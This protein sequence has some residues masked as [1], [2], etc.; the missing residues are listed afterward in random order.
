M[1]Y[2]QTWVGWNRLTSSGN[3]SDS[4]VAIIIAGYNIE[5][6]AGGGASPYFL[7]GSAGT[8]PIAFRGDSSQAQASTSRTIDLPALGIGLSSGCY[9][10][11]DANTAAVTVFYALNG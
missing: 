2:N 11:F 3:V 6:G 9:V 7:N 4:G 1:G 5:S 10:S 8:A